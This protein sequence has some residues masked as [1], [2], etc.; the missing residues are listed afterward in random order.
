MNKNYNKDLFEELLGSTQYR[1]IYDI[2]PNK[3]KKF[4]YNDI[5]WIGD[6]L[7][8]HGDIPV[9]IVCHADIVGIDYP[10]EFIYEKNDSIIRANNRT[11]G[12]DDR[13]GQYILLEA[14]KKLNVRP[15]IAITHDEEKGCIGADEFVT[16]MPYNEYEI[17][18]LIELDRRGSNDLVYYDCDGHDEFMKFCEDMTGWKHAYGSYSDICSFMDEWKI[19]GVNLSC[20]YY[21]EHSANEHV[22]IDEML[23]VVDVLANW[24][25]NIDYDTLPRFEH[26]PKKQ[27]Y[28]SNWDWLLDSYDEAKDL[29]HSE[30]YS[31]YDED[32]ENIIEH[33]GQAYG[34]CA[35]CGCLVPM[36]E[37][38]MKYGII[39][40]H[41]CK[42][43]Y[44][45]ICSTGDRSLY[46]LF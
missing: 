43:Y 17:K 10:T 27:S 40:C 42:G 2:M 14:M 16:K 18:F 24:L 7:F 25:N 23:N 13:C 41:E 33:E 21:N 39:L 34:I 35:D 20:G 11:L 1:L 3:L 31:P 45:D 28:S 26:T 9:M 4:G 5:E 44:D 29:Y 30:E 6:N 46:K 12:G 38:A 8:A 22:V 15:Y 36:T 37:E 19:C 32:A